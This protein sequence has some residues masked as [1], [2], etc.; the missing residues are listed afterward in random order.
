MDIIKV[1]DILEATNG[2]LVAGSPDAEVCGVTIDSRKVE[3]SYLFVAIKGENTDG[4][5]YISSA[6]DLGASCVLVSSDAEIPEGLSAVK[7]SDTVQAL[8][9]LG[10]TYLAKLP[11][12]RI[13]VTGSV[14]KTTTRDLLHAALSSVYKVGK[15]S[16]NFNNDIGLPLTVLTFDSSMDIGVM[17]MGTMGTL[18]EID[19]LADIGR[20]EAAIITN[21]GVSHMETL[22]SRD[23]ILKTKLEITDYFTQE[24]T[25]I[26]N[27]DDD[28]LGPLNKS[29]FNFKIIK[30]GTEKAFGDT[31]YL[32]TNIKDNGL[33]GTE[34]TLE[35]DGESFEIKLPIPGAHNALNAA[36]AIAGAEALGVSIKDAIRGIA[37][38][39]PTGSRLRIVEVGGIKIIDDSYNAAPASMKAALTTLKNSDGKRKIAVL[40]DMNELGED[41]EALHYDVGSFAASSGV[42]ILVTVGEK[43][44]AI[45]R[46]AE[47]HKK[48]SADAQKSGMQG[49]TEIHR[50]ESIDAALKILTPILSEGDL[51]LVKASRGMKLDELVKNLETLF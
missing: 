46:G 11:M 5:N 36:L 6:K 1:K 26:V 47:E 20:P 15:N 35:K 45:S 33:L 29:D 7:V 4:H 14:G 31:D 18:G 21:I 9:E 30:V 8:Q 41:S 2:K 28:K 17:E 24:N 42:D 44:L 37:D 49:L 50:C 23:N 51:L 48:S 12:R 43:A 3:Q 34:F 13:A 32:V 25:L 38:M 27:A 40:G 10:K 19:R 39:V 16:G 22:G